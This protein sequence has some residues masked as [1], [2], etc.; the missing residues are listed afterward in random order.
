MPVTIRELERDREMAV[1]A[2]EA[3]VVVVVGSRGGGRWREGAA[4]GFSLSID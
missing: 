1:A 2:V 3:A 4:G